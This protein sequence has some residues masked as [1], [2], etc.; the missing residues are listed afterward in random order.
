M[1]NTSLA[2][3]AQYKSHPERRGI[4]VQV[5]RVGWGVHGRAPHCVNTSQKL[6]PHNALPRKKNLEKTDQRAPKESPDSPTEREM[7]HTIPS[8]PSHPEDPQGVG[9]AMKKGVTNKRTDRSIKKEEAG[10]GGGLW[11]SLPEYPGHRLSV[12]CVVSHQADTQPHIHRRK[13]EGTS[14]KRAR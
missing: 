9:C 3:H 5:Q 4:V 10:E 8:P 12:H 6:A 2:L 7:Y 13:I 14:D 11:L 1:H